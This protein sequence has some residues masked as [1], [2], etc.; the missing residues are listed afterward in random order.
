MF[1]LKQ[2]SHEQWTRIMDAMS[3]GIRKIRI[4]EQCLPCLTSVYRLPRSYE[5]VRNAVL[6]I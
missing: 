5:E 4:T 3:F 6:L 2:F 1:N